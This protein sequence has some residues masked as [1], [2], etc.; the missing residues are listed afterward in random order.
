MGSR[1]A[2]GDTA[3]RERIAIASA[4][5]VGGTSGE[6][7]R[8]PVHRGGG[9]ERSGRLAEPGR[10]SES[11]VVST[12]RK[13]L[14][15]RDDHPEEAE[16]PL[17]TTARK[18][19]P[20]SMLGCV[21][22]YLSPSLAGWGLR[23]GGNLTYPSHMYRHRQNRTYRRQLGPLYH[24]QPRPH[25]CCYPCLRRHHPFGCFPRHLHGCH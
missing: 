22:C 21:V 12:C 4:L 24:C 7:S 23:G 3:A 1:I 2:Q 13:W 8:P 18:R 25:S 10:E 5:H 6:K 17:K 20:W 14:L 11:G 19:K 15:Q 16:K 9:K